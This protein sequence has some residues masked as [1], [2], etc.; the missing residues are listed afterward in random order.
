MTETKKKKLI[1]SIVMYFVAIPIAILLGI[2]LL[3][4]RQYNLISIIVAGMACLPFFIKFEKSQSSAREIIVIAVMTA[5]AVVGRLV[6]VAIPGF[7]PVTAIVIITAIAYGKDAGFLTGA[8]SALVSNIYFGQGPWTPFQMVAWGFIGFLAGVL[9]SKSDKPKM[10][11]LIVIGII[12]GVIFSMMMDVWTVFSI[13][14]AFNL[15]RYLV[16]VSTSF[17]FMAVYAGSNAIFLVL[18]TKPILEKLN[19]VKIKYGVFNN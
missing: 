11:L 3:N 18:L 17:P 10:W 8:M 4:D 9:F 14:G 7:K 6:F 5:L 12:G 2:V 13:D 16:A 19:R 1:F 15:S